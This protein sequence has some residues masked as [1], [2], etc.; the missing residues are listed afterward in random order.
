MISSVTNYTQ[1]L[2]IL[3]L[4][5]LNAWLFENVTLGYFKLKVGLTSPPLLSRWQW[6]PIIG[7]FV[8]SRLDRV[9]EK[10]R[11]YIHTYVSFNLTVQIAK[12]LFDLAIWQFFLCYEEN[13]RFSYLMTISTFQA[14]HFCSSL[15]RRWELQKT[16]SV[17][18]KMLALY[19]PQEYACDSTKKIERTP[20]FHFTKTQLTL[21]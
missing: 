18:Q 2:V 12:A 13:M 14:R 16:L 11:G 15:H 21:R 1:L 6:H 5:Y 9:V 4:G 7:V 8:V 19:P 20:P 10:F 17:E 3:K